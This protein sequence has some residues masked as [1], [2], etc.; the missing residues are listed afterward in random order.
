[1]SGF[2]F[3]LYFNCNTAPMVKIADVVNTTCTNDSND[4]YSLWPWHRH[5]YNLEW[6]GFCSAML[7][8][9]YVI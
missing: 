8:E 4:K 9:A 2:L 5:G 7:N 1:M 3:R 6:E